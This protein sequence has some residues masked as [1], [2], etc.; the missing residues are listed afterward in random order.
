[1]RTK[2]KAFLLLLLLRSFEC[3]LQTSEVFPPFDPLLPANLAPSL[4]TSA[5]VAEC[6]AV[7]WLDVDF[8]SSF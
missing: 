1:M 3:L 7:A 8:G 6:A 5:S 4:A 2:L